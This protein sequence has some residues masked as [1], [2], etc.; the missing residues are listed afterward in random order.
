VSELSVLYVSEINEDMKAPSDVFYTTLQNRLVVPVEAVFEE[1]RLHPPVH[2]LHVNPHVNPPHL[3]RH[4]LSLPLLV[5]VSQATMK[6]R[7]RVGG[8]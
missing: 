5:S 6:L 4:L 3:P 7:S 8:T 1:F 2:H